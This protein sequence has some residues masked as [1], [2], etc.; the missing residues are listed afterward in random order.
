MP[1][2][3]SLL[4]YLANKG[5]NSKKKKN[6]G[7]RKLTYKLMGSSCFIS[8]VFSYISNYSLSN[9]EIGPFF[10]LFKFLKL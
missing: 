4:A 1:T 8:F 2:S 10:T 6:K 7:R 3:L 5:K 9:S